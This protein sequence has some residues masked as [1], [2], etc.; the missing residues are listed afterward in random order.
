MTATFLP[1][2]VS[3][4]LGLT[5]PS[6]KACSMLACSFSRQVTGS[7]Q[8]RLSTQLFS[9][10]AGQIRPVNSGKSLVSVKNLKASSH[11]PLK[12]ESCQANCLLP[13]GQAQWQ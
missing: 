2:R 8:E 10:S 6:R 13:S 5:Y 11:L 4:T 1:L 7:P 12:S 3:G 9:Q